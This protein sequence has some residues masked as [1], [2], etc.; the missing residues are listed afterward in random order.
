MA[1]Q[2]PP[3]GSPYQPLPEFMSGHT[4]DP[5]ILCVEKVGQAICVRE[6]KEMHVTVGRGFTRCDKCGRQRRVEMADGT[7]VGL[8]IAGVGEVCSVCVEKVGQ[9]RC[10]RGGVGNARVGGWRVRPV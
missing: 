4:S 3:D 7:S 1:A 9:A 5:P 6:G 10:V 2:P 8:R